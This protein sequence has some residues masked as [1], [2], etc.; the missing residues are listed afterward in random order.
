MEDKDEYSEQMLR[1]FTGIYLCHNRY[2]LGCEYTLIGLEYSGKGWG[3]PILM[4]EVTH[5]R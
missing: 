1:I 3:M 2:S 4:N 5:E